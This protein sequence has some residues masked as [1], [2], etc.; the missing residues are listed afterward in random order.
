MF[1]DQ[2][3]CT[4]TETQSCVSTAELH[5]LCLDAVIVVR[6]CQPDEIR[7]RRRVDWQVRRQG[8]AKGEPHLPEPLTR[9]EEGKSLGLPVVNRPFGTVGAYVMVDA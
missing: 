5:V 9:S 6:L 3:Q 7:M 8:D 1:Q 2:R 4:A